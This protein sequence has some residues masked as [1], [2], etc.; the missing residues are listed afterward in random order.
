MMK[1]PTISSTEMLNCTTTRLLRSH[2]EPRPVV[3][4]PLSTRMGWK[5]D[6]KNAGYVPASAPTTS[7]STTRNAQKAGSATGRDSGFSRR[8]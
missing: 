1:V 4:L 7:V 8:R 6:R 3:N 5:A 2:A